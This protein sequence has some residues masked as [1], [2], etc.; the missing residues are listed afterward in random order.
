MAAPIAVERAFGIMLD[1]DDVAGD[2]AADEEE[3]EEADD[4]GGRNALLGEQL[5]ILLLLL[6]MLL[7]LLLLLLGALADVRDILEGP[8]CSIARNK[9][10]SQRRSTSSSTERL[11]CGNSC[12]S[13]SMALGETIEWLSAGQNRN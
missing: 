6:W 13:I 2:M 7:L 9:S 4:V 11:R 12:T 8:H 3:V 5:I 1:E 10:R